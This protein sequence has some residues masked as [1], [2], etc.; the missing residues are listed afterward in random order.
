M[1]NLPCCNSGKL[2]VSELKNS[3]LFGI[4]IEIKDTGEPIGDDVYQYFIDAAY[5]KL[6]ELYDIQIVPKQITEN[7]DLFYEEAN[8][9]FFKFNTFK[10]P[11]LWE[12]SNR[13]LFPIKVEAFYGAD[14]ASTEFPIEWLRVNKGAASI[15]V[16]PTFGHMGSFLHQFT[17]IQASTGLYRRDFVPQYYQVT[18][19]AG[20]CPI[21]PFVNDLV[22]KIATIGMLNI[23]GDIMLG[24][25]IA[26][27]SIGMDG[28]S[29]SI[30]TTQSAEN[31]ATSA[32]IK[33]Y[34][35]ELKRDLPIFKARYGALNLAG[36]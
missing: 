28:L 23:A 10:A 18:Y 12:P 1:A 31:S 13:E 32:R 33:K 8:R 22:A 3:Y 24:A 26:S 35:D 14:I 27:Y 5:D 25:G 21:P 16:Y 29:Q 9:S 15:H 4:P 17:A 6:S 30:S 36:M 2:T 34:E 20:F 11:I 19:W 7:H